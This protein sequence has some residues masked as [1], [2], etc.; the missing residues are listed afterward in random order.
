MEALLEGRPLLRIRN[1]IDLLAGV[2]QTSDD[3]STSALTGQ[4]LDTL[5]AAILARLRSGDA[6]TGEPALNNLR[7]LEAVTSA[8]SAL[9]A[10]QAANH[11]HLPHELLLV[12]LHAALTALDTLTGVTTTDDILSLIFS[13]FCIGK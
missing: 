6:A 1:K 7:Q 10:A 3:I 2:E 13:T 8:L 5:R 11:D 4:G 9:A 12:D